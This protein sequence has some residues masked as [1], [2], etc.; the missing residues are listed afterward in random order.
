MSILHRDFETYSTLDLTRCG[1]WR[2]ATDPIT[3]VWCVAYA[4]DDQP[5]QVWLPG[6]PIPDVFFKAARDL[7]WKVAAVSRQGL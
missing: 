1:G 2:Y 3:G 5:T 6:N 7:D 4:V